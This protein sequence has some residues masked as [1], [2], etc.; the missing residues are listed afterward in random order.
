MERLHSTRGQGASA[1]EDFCPSR[2]KRTFSFL[3]TARSLAARRIRLNGCS[4]NSRFLV[5]QCPAV[6]E[7][8]SQLLRARVH[9]NLKAHLTRMGPQ[10]RQISGNR[11]RQYREQVRRNSKDEADLSSDAKIKNIRK[12]KSSSRWGRVGGQNTLLTRVRHPPCPIC[13][14]FS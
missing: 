1:S 6:R 5:R 4:M 2:V 8:A 10:L 14:H 3:R 7:Q 9:R 13:P 11:L 12:K